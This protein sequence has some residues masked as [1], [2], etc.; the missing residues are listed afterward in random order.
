M[1]GRKYR[2]ARIHMRHFNLADRA[3][4]IHLEIGDCLLPG[5]SSAAG[6]SRCGCGLR[7]RHDDPA[8]LDIELARQ[9][10]EQLKDQIMA[11]WK[12]EHPPFGAVLFEGATIADMFYGKDD[13]EYFDFNSIHEAIDALKENNK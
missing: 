5:A 10:W 2:R 9:A 1:A 7:E 6:I 12:R 3:L 8:S 4:R 13:H 11:D